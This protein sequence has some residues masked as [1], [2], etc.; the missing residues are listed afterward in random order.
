MQ[1]AGHPPPLPS[2]HPG[3]FTSFFF[4]VLHSALRNPASSPHSAQV[5]PA[6]PRLTQL[7]PRTRP[8]SVQQ[9]RAFLTTAICLHPQLHISPAPPSSL[10]ARH[11]FPLTLHV[12]CQFVHTTTALSPHSPLHS[13]NPRYYPPLFPPL[14]RL[15]SPSPICLP[16]HF[17]FHLFSFQT[18][19]GNFR[20]LP[21][22][23]RSRAGCPSH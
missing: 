1:S 21:A 9:L 12:P 7:F 10:P 13:I 22:C 6:L 23:I 15:L 8:A 11:R 3:F 2:S 17:C 4:S 14:H 18:S 16:N 5:F 20:L 19:S